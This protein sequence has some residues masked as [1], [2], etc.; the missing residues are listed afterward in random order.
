M[1]KS[2]TKS[3]TRKRSVSKPSTSTAR[4]HPPADVRQRLT[5]AASQTPAAEP[6]DTPTVAKDADSDAELEREAAR[7]ARSEGQ[8]LLM[9]VPGSLQQIGDAIGA[10]KQAVALWK[11]GSRIPEERWRLKL[12]ARYEIP[13]ESWDRAPG[14]SGERK[15]EWFPTDGTEPNALDDC[16]R[17][18]ALLRSQLNRDNLIGRERIQLGDAFSRAL[19]QK[20]RLE[21][22]REMLE[23][24][25]IRDHAE[26]KRLKRVIIAALLPFPEASKAVEA[27]ILD[28]LG[29]DAA[30][31]EKAVR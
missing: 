29:D 2:A 13:L 23:T 17:L 30:E 24:R 15:V 5:V 1:P 26:W 20:E 25:T 27:A 3:V 10:T 4:E 14:T 7:I 22:A 19:A 12:Q 6:K 9:A 18:L 16:N 8:R 11:T 28:V 21:R 31:L